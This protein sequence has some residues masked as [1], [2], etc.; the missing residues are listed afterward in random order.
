LTLVDRLEALVGEGWRVPFTVRT[1]IN[2]DSF[3]EIIDQMRASVPQELSQAEELLERRESLLT[4]A[5]AEAEEI[6]LSARERTERAIDEH[7]VVAAARTEGEGL[8]A[9]AQLEAEETRRGADDYALGVLSELESRLSSLLR[10]TSNG[11]GT[12]KRR[13]P[14]VSPED[15]AEGA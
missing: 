11:L 10:T 3:F 5:A 8:K 2:E 14:P 15:L 9:Q 6:I 7:E 4:S 1:V 13:R 12:L